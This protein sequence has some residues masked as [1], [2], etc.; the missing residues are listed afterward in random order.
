MVIGEIKGHWITVTFRHLLSVVSFAFSIWLC[1]VLTTFW[2]KKRMLR[3]GS[4]LYIDSMF[5]GLCHCSI[6]SV[7]S[8]VNHDFAPNW[9]VSNKWC[10]LVQIDSEMRKVSLLLMSRKSSF[11]KKIVSGRVVTYTRI[12]VP[13]RRGGLFKDNGKCIPICV[14]CTDTYIYRIRLFC[15]RGKKICLPKQIYYVEI[16]VWVFS[17]IVFIIHVSRITYLSRAYWNAVSWIFWWTLSLKL[18]TMGASSSWASNIT[19]SFRWR[20]LSGRVCSL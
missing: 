5:N 20:K 18:C 12:V 11:T 4:S 15:A 9:K 8:N 17:A 14:V 1:G 16:F 2:W 13:V 3:A 7:S 6:V 10:Y 19:V